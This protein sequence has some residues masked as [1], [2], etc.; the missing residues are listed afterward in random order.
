MGR[1]IIVSVGE[2]R[3][4]LTY[5]AEAPRTEGLNSMVTVRCDCGKVKDV[6]KFNF[7][8]GEIQ[9]CGCVSGE[10]H[11]HSGEKLYR[12]WNAMKDRCYRHNGQ[13]LTYKKKGITVCDEWLNSYTAFRVWALSNG[14]KEGLQIDRERNNEGY[15]PSNC[16]WVTSMVNNNNR[17]N[18]FT[19]L[20]NGQE[21]KIMELLREKGI[22]Q[23]HRMA[24][25]KRLQLG[26]E[27]EKAIDTPFRKMKPY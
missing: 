10:Q 8:H 11:G 22:D 21:W 9:S 18:E 4:M 17:G 6:N 19:I 2:K 12:I 15:S 1:K 3:N 23:N 7:L 16:R 13:N 24:I 14:Y 20:Y 26:W 5:I 25:K 27:P